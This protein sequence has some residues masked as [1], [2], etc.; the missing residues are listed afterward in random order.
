MKRFLILILLLPVFCHANKTD[1][2]KILFSGYITDNDD[3]GIQYATVLL[4]NGAKSQEGTVADSLGYFKMKVPQGTYTLKVQCIGY[5]SVQKTVHIAD[6][7]T[8]TIHLKNSFTEM[9]EVVVRAQN[10]QRKA[11][12][13]IIQIPP[14]LN[15][16]GEDLLRQSPGVWVSKDDISINGSGGTKVYVNEREIRLT[17]EQLITYLQSLKSEDIQRIEVLPISGANEDADAKGGSIHIYLRKYKDEG[18]RTS[19]TWENSVGAS[20]QSYHPSFSINAHKGKM[21]M[22]AFGSDNYQP[23]NKG[24]IT[25]DRIYADPNSYFTSY[26]K[27]KVPTYNQTARIGSVY[28]IDEKNDVGAEFEYTHNYKNVKSNNHSILSYNDPLY[29]IN[30]DGDYRQKEI[31]ETYSVTANYQHKLD[32]QGSVFKVITDYISKNSVSNNLYNILQEKNDT[33]YNSHTKSVYNIASTNVSLKKV[34]N[35]KTSWEAGAKYTSTYMKDQANYEGLQA[36]NN[37]KNIPEYQYALKYEERIGA[38]YAL[39]NTEL[40]NLSMNAGLRFERTN[41][42]D[43]T[44]HINKSY[45][46]LY[47]HLNLTYSFDHLR[48]W[49]LATQLSR[50]IERPAFYQLNPNRI[51]SSEYSYMIGNP[52]LKPTYINKLTATLIYNY[53]YTLT[54]G[55]NLHHNL[56]REFCKQDTLNSNTSYITYENHYRENHWFVAITTPFQ[57]TTWFNFTMNFIG[58]KQCIKMTP[59]SSFKNHYLLF[60]NINSTFNLPND[61]S[62]ELQY[63]GNNRLYSGN[64]QVEPYQIMSVLCRKKWNGGKW[65]ATV[66]VNNVFNNAFKYG[67][68]LSAYSIKTD[69]D[70][71]SQGRFVKFALTWNF[72]LGKKTKNTKLE[73]SSDSERDR[74]NQKAQ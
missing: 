5:A 13:F 15:K 10:I 74:L 66:S 27:I 54:I 72:N 7:S 31:Y 28:A 24:R 73:N 56:I 65:V 59:E 50:N 30:S 9:K 49:M 21:D 46:N 33:T 8:E 34:L 38:G 52:N 44:N 55:G 26:S 11:D 58:V 62:M 53:R 48:K 71:A 2:D 16:N 32:K 43:H 36:D 37:W 4:M 61:Y 40:G 67:S 35:P 42:S 47:P 70:L 64:S 45:N 29:S 41:T 60:L 39:F 12:R 17:G 20:L 63:N 18:F 69:Y 51:Q 1:Q 14:A 25:S 6:N 57:P 19:I 68:D 23:I 22:Y 3:K